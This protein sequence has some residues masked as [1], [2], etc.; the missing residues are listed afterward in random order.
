MDSE[1]TGNLSDQVEDAT[2]KS[3]QNVGGLT[4][5][6]SLAA[7]DTAEY[8]KLGRRATLKMDFVIMPILVVMYV[9]NYLDRQNIA[10][11]KLA[12]IERDLNLSPVDYQTAVSILFCGYSMFYFSYLPPEQ[13][14]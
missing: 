1:K 13:Y 5:P 11:A 9:L 10:S 12:N 4:M 14:G 2:L 3:Q 6:A 8:N 7:L